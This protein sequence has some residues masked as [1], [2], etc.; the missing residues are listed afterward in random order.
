[1]Q[2]W[3]TAGQESF[4]S[5]TKIFYRG[6]HCIFFVYDITR[7]G[8]FINLRHWFDEVI[9]QSE[10]DIVMFLIGNKKDKEADRAVSLE[11]AEQFRKEKG[12]HFF[13]EASARSGENVERMFIMA[14]KM[15]YHNYKDK[16][17]EMVSILILKDGC[18]IERRGFK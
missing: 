6:A 9:A 7:L 17:T 16:I 14:S 1:L 5:I 15:L 12:I 2:I 4:I 13:F 11:K 10:P 8:T 18:F 3:D